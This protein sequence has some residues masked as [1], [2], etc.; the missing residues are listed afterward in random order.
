MN[1]KTSTYL[2]VLYC[3]VLYSSKTLQCETI[4]CID[5]I[6]FVRFPLFVALVALARLVTLESVKFMIY[7]M[8]LTRRF[9][10]SKRFVLAALGYVPI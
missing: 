8:D 10:H 1:K 4:Y 2:Y 5:C 7:V 6:R 3:T 9:H